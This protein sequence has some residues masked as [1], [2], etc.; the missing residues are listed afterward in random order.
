MLVG[1]TAESFLR[2]VRF[3]REAL[4]EDPGHRQLLAEKVIGGGRTRWHPAGPA[5]RE[6]HRLAKELALS[7]TE[8]LNLIEGFP[9]LKMAVRGWVAEEHLYRLVSKV[10]GVTHC[11][12]LKRDGQP[13][14]GLR[15]RGQP[16]TIECKNVLRKKTAAG[17]PRVDF[18]RTRASMS[19]PCS[20]YYSPTDFGVVA[21]CLH[22]VSEKWEFRFV[23]SVG[24]APHR[25]CPGKLDSNVRV[26]A[27]WLAD[28]A[29]ALLAAIG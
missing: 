3:E 18:Q 12:R 1:G 23:P 15:F 9:R 26:D 8:V 25:R 21:A 17:L 2:Y 29:K 16:L 28:P 13:D 19:D 22:A 11:E 5:P 27:R 14:I 24:L 6:L 4:R 20:R 10:P 7:E